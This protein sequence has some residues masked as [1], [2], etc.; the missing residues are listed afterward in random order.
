MPLRFLDFL[1]LE[2]VETA[3]LYRAG[4]LVRV[5]DP[6]RFAIHKLLLSA[7]RASEV[8][9]SRKDLVQ[10]EI[11]LIALASR[12]PAG[13]KLAWREARRRGPAWRRLLDAS[14]KRLAP[15]AQLVLDAP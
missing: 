14:R 4:V 13:L 5:P 9:K 1:L 15:S 10:G 3:L 11:L 7:R 2:P 12:D 8:P 6:A